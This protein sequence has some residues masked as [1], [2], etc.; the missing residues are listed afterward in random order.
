MV[1]IICVSKKE[2]D[3]DREK[4]KINSEK[5]SRENRK[6]DR[7]EEKRSSLHMERLLQ[8]I[9]RLLL[10]GWRRRRRLARLARAGVS[11]LPRSLLQ[12]AQVGPRSAGEQMASQS[13]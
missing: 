3:R 9:R 11:T 4:K 10:I 6:R 12:A 2:R 13:L 5:T 8:L 1:Y 7:E